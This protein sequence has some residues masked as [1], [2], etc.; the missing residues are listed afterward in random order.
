MKRSSTT[1]QTMTLKGRRIAMPHKSTKAWIV[2]RNKVDDDLYDEYGKPLEVE[3]K[4]EFIAISDDGQ[5]IV[6]D[7]MDQVAFQAIEEFG[8]GNFALRKIGH[9][10]LGKWLQIAA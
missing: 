7:D 10:V 4:G 5:T 8:S 3:H 6:G 9:V 2:K 1:I